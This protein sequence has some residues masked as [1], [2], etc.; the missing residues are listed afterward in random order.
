MTVQHHALIYTAL[1]FSAHRAQLIFKSKSFILLGGPT[2]CVAKKGCRIANCSDMP[3]A[4]IQ[5]HKIR[6]GEEKE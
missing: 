1:L 6:I 5:K 2:Q 3:I 4:H